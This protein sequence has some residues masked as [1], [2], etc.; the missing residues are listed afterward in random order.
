MV[1][2]GPEVREDA[3]HMLHVL[4]TREW[5][6][7]GLARGGGGGAAG[8]GAFEGRGTLEELL[9]G[10]EDALRGAGGG[11]RAVCCAVLCCAALC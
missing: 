10:W 2:P 4:S 1:D 9:E 6:G 7:D 8:A 11:E 5:H 3:L